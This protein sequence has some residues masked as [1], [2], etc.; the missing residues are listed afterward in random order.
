M[1]KATRGHGLLEVEKYRN[2]K[3]VKKRRVVEGIFGS[4]K[5]WYGWRKTKYMGLLR[6]QLA[7]ILTAI[8]WNMK[9]WATIE[10]LRA[11]YA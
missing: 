2:Q 5:Q 1:T 7:V 9:K 4:W 8:A 3:I 10:Q 6:N 11:N